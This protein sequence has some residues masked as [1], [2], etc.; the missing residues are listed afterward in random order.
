MT[1]L[2]KYSTSINT[3]VNTSNLT[4]FLLVVLIFLLIKV[5]IEPI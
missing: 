2:K 5:G 1:P 3:F 4:L